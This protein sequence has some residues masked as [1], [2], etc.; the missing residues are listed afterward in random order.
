M[1]T[2]KIAPIASSVAAGF[3]VNNPF[4]GLQ[5]DQWGAGIA[6]NKTNK[7]YFPLQN[8]RDSEFIAETY[9]NIVLSKVL[10]L[11]PSVQLIVNPALSP[12]ASTA[13]V[14]TLRATGLF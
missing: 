10:Q 6:W 7:A 3:V 2:G 5:G 4:G 8:V 9:F 13:G 1:A 14:F 11:G 12:Q